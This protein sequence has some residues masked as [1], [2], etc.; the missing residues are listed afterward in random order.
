MRSALRDAV[1]HLCSCWDAL[2]TLEEQFEDESLEIETDNIQ[3]LAGEIAAD[4]A[5][6]YKYNKVPD[7]LLDEY[8]ARILEE[9]NA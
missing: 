5:Q 9:V 4:P 8:L 7:S 1:F 6:V 3:T 2:R